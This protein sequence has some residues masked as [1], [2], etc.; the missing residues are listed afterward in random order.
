MNAIPQ[1]P[2][3]VVM[4]RLGL[5]MTEGTIVEWNK[6]DGEWV[7]KGEDLFTFESDKSAI[8]IEA[9]ASGTLH[10]LVSAGQTVAVQT[11]VAVIGS[12]SE[13]GT[14]SAVAGH[15]EAGGRATSAGI[16]G[17]KKDRTAIAASPRARAQAKA[18]GIRL[19]E[20]HGSGPRGMIVVA[21]LDKA[22]RPGAIQATPV[23]RKLAQEAGLDLSSIKGTGSNQR[24]TRTDVELAIATATTPSRGMT[25]LRAIIAKRLSEGWRERPQVT[26][27]TD[28]DAVNLIAVRE[29]L[30]NTSR[31]KIPF[32]ALFVR[33]AARALAEFPYMNATF[34][35]AGPQQLPD[36]HVG[37]AVD[38]ERGLL[39]PVLHHADRMTLGETC[40]ALSRLMDEAQ[41]GR[42]LPDDLSGGT[43]TLTNLGM[44]GIDAFTPIINPPET[45]ILGIGRIVARPV[46]WGGTVVLREQLTL[47]LSFDHRLV[48]GAPAA[49]FLARIRELIEQPS[50][51][52][53]ES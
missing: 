32:D 29:A 27:T 47:S 26:L 50:V 40:Q 19:G 44:Y 30:S 39:V 51:V 9:P 11:P 28:A 7:N 43:F 38:T 46:G 14:I 1:E 52:F 34:T 6:L 42:S 48:D 36:I 21:D 33:I 35:P 31:D 3:V 18:R 49:K 16:H 17:E 25:G 12:R 24:V 53:A 13:P 10:I 4:P 15:V 5:S 23:A 8:A 41:H 20:I 22:P 2:H 45:G 37:V